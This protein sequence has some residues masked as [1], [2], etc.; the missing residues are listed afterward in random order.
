[1]KFGAANYLMGGRVLGVFL[2]P[3]RPGSAVAHQRH[4]L[5]PVVRPHA[6]E[7]E[8]APVRIYKQT[9]HVNTATGYLNV[10]GV[11]VGSAT[12]RTKLE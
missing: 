10:L 4:P 12:K 1:M 8:G 11:S 3:Q 5:Q 7:L 2:Q 9:V 6:H